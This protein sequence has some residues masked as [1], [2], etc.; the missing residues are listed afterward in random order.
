VNRRA[1][2]TRRVYALQSTITI[3]EDWTVFVS[4]KN[5]FRFATGALALVLSLVVAA[6]WLGS[7]NVFSAAQTSLR[8]GSWL[9]RPI[10]N[11]NEKSRQLPAPIAPV[12]SEEIN[13]R[14]PNLV[15]QVEA[16]YER[17]IVDAGWLLFGPVQS[18]GVTKVVM[19]M[20]GADDLCHPAGYQAFVYIGNKYAGTLSPESMLLSTSGALTNI[21]LLSSNTIA[22]EFARY[23]EHDAPCCPTRVSYVTF[24]ILEGED[25]IIHPTEIATRSLC[26]PEAGDSTN[27]NARLF[28][29]KWRLA[30]IGAVT[31]PPNAPYIKF[32]RAAKIFSGNS[33]CNQIAGAFEL[34]GTSLSLRHTLRT[35]F[36]CLDPE[37]QQLETDLMKAL[38]QT[39]RFELQGDLLQL[40]D[41]SNLLLIF[42]ADKTQR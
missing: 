10:V 37:T 20:S 4:R 6:A 5:V 18:F 39:T 11:W 30:Q 40:Y 25:P 36:V 7:K 19:A 2:K 21:R 17:E 41:C 24:E 26:P 14:C 31:L 13:L 1:N 35:N 27:A 23:R 22:A 16:P 15:R 3:I 33:G 29:V 12:N 34:D 8:A 28:E 38:Q 42:Q 9:D 32:E